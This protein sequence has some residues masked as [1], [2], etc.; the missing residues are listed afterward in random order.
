[1]DADHNFSVRY[2]NTTDRPQ[3]V[4]A[5]HRLTDPNN[6][7]AS[8]NAKDVHSIERHKIYKSLLRGTE[9]LPKQWEPR[10][11]PSGHS[12]EFDGRIVIGGAHLFYL[13]V[14]IHLF[15]DLCWNWISFTLARGGID[16]W[17]ASAEYRKVIPRSH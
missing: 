9:A 5:F 16:D 17:L 6:V 14:E 7:S 11:L 13:L 3:F 10:F 4:F 2:V 15:I 1:M 8:Y 12:V